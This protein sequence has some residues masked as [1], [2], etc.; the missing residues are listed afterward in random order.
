MKSIFFLFLGILLFVANSCVKNNPDPSWLEVTK[1]TL[2]ANPN[3][4]GQEGALTQN[5]T[6][7][8]VYIDDEIVGVFEVPFKIPILKEGSVN[9]KIY[10]A[11]KN[12]GISATKKVYPFLEPF[13]ITGNLV[14]NQTLTLT[15]TTRY[16]SS[17][18]FI[19]EDFE[20]ASNLVDDPNSAAQITTDSD[21]LILEDFNG[22]YYGKIVLNSTDT[23]WIGYTNAEMDLPRSAEV[24]LEIDYYNTNAVITGLLAISPSGVQPNPNVQLNAQSP[25]SVKWKKIYIDLRELVSNSNPSA[26]F[27]QSFQAELDQGDTEGLII[28]DNIKVVHF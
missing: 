5:L 10:P 17:T 1:W 12:N 28:I 6:E 9:I 2:N 14:K 13:V 25:S 22:G 8:W 27:E 26:Y 23:T 20:D 18:V 3:L 11:V 7:A 15:P 4:S 24:Y 21:P 19:I 16:Y